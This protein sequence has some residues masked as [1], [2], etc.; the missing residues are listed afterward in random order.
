MKIPRALEGWQY[1]NSLLQTTPSFEID[2]HGR[3]GNRGVHELLRP[4]H[5]VM[6]HRAHIFVT[7]EDVKYISDLVRSHTTLH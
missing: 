1:C 5:I 4:I 2:K 6:Y 3:G 7:M